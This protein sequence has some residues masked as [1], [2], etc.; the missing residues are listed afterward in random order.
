MG[1]PKDCAC[2]CVF[3]FVWVTVSVSVATTAISVKG[4]N[5]IL[6]SMKDK[7]IILRENDSKHL[8]RNQRLDVVKNEK[9]QTFCLSQK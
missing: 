9:K 8:H 1:I 6:F 7:K 5:P 2:V 4:K 3:A